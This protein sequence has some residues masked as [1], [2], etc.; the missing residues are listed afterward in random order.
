YSI[1]DGIKSGGDRLIH[2]SPTALN[3]VSAPPQQP[4]GSKI[5]LTN[6]GTNLLI[7]IPKTKGEIILG[8]LLSI[9]LLAIMFFFLVVLLLSSSIKKLPLVCLIA[10]ISGLII[11]LTLICDRKLLK[12]N[13]KE[14]CL[15]STLFGVILFKKRLLKISDTESKRLESSELNKLRFQ[16][17]NYLFWETL[18][19]KEKEW[20]LQEINDFFNLNHR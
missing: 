16:L 1:N 8:I 20:L 11:P 4:A 19:Q 17:S 3:T 12:I 9:I 14:F 2:N 5:V 10:S 6:N 7:E 13:L 18:G 15:E